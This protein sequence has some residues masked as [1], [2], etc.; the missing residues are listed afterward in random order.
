MSLHAAA[1]AVIPRS[2]AQQIPDADTLN[3]AARDLIPMLRRLGRRHDA[4][5]RPSDEAAGA[6]REVGFFRICQSIEN[7]GY[8]LPPSVLWRV[9][10]EIARGDTSTAWVL[11]LARLHPWMA[12][13]FPVAAQDGVFEGGREGLQKRFRQPNAEF[14][15]GT[16]AGFGPDDR[17]VS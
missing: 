6:I 9:A 14:P 15:L 13:M 3:G 11:S 5:R 8:G 17:R 2:A 12:G 16:L 10:R 4:E 7:G 1:Q